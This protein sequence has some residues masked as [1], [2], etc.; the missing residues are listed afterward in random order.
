MLK[1]KLI[2][3]VA[4]GVLLALS[5]YAIAQPSEGGLRE[6]GILLL[7]RPTG[8]DGSSMSTLNSREE[9]FLN[10]F[11]QDQLLEVASA[12]LAVQKAED[13]QVAQYALQLVNDHAQ[14]NQQLIRLARQKGAVLPVDLDREGRARLERLTQLQGVAFDQEY[15][16]QAIAANNS[17]IDNLQQAAQTIEDPEIQA[18]INE[19]LPI[20]QQ[21]LQLA[22]TLGNGNDSSHR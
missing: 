22:T 20:Q 6:Q 13:P 5:E 1:L 17:D 14:Y 18:F 12:Q 19:F 9:R 7:R 4:T 10:S 16:Q 3:L 21:H 11:T 8:P 15:L 2:T